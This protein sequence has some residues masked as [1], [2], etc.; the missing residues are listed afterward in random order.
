MTEGG[1]LVVVDVIDGSPSQ[2]A[3]LRPGDAILKLDNEPLSDQPQFSAAV[4]AH[5]AGDQ[6]KLRIRGGD[7]ATE[8]DVIIT[9][10]SKPKDD[11]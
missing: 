6:V 5:A 7:P 8:R 2:K 10:G 1:H 11:E 9:L 3:G 4:R